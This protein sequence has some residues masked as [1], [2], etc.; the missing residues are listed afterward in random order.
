[1]LFG[2]CKSSSFSLSLKIGFDPRLL[3]GFDGY[4]I[5][6]CFKKSKFSISICYFLSTII[7]VNRLSNLRLRKI[8]YRTLLEIKD[9]FPGK[10]VTPLL[11]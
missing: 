3:E 6:S 2:W 9:L 10:L 5:S 4:L 7:L 11:N 1:M 8:P